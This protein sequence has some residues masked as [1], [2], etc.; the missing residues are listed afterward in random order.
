[1]KSDPLT[2]TSDFGAGIMTAE[3]VAGLDLSAC[4]LAVL[5]A[6][7]TGRGRVAGGEGVIGLQRS[8]HAAGARTLM[9]SLLKVDDEATRELMTAFYDNLW[10][11]RLGPLEA[12]R[13][14]QLSTLAGGRVVGR[15][16]GIGPTEPEPVA[17]TIARTH[18]KF[19][20]AW[21]LSGDL[22]ESSG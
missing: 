16:R 7:E 5:S 2:G 17:V 9:A 13:E 14:A 4:E 6:C 19:W 12:L 8:F 1:P 21:V 18:P 15:D 20:A 11:R 3:E 22:G 10:R